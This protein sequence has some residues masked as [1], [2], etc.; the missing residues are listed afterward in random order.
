MDIDVTDLQVYQADLNATAPKIDEWLNVAIQERLDRHSLE[1]VFAAAGLLYR[2][3]TE[4][5]V[6]SMVRRWYAGLNEE[7]RSGL[8]VAFREQAEL[9]KR[10][11]ELLDAEHLFERLYYSEDES[12]RMQFLTE[13]HEVREDLE[14][15]AV[16]LQLN[17][18]YSD[19]LKSLREVVDKEG[20]CRLTQLG[21]IVAETNVHWCW[22]WRSE[23]SWREPYAWWAFED[24]LPEPDRQQVGEA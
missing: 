4:V 16:V 15:L 3:H 5:V 11:Y 1:G 13:L 24:A 23:L 9:V 22:Q 7:Q 14:N 20:A 17:K 19:F 18:V 8:V 21:E 12:F 10:S 6:T 2:Y